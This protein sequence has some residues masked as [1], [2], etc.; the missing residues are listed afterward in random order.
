[1]S[2]TFA[3]PS[4]LLAYAGELLPTEAWLADAAPDLDRALADFMARCRDFGF[5]PTVGGDDLVRHADRGRTLAEWVGAVGS[6]FAAADTFPLAGSPGV[7]GIDDLELRTYLEAV[8][9]FLLVEEAE[10][11]AAG[12][13]AAESLRAAVDA[14]D[15]E[16]VEAL[17]RSLGAFEDDDVFT[18][19]FVLGAG[20]LEGLL[21]RA[22][23]LRPRSNVAVRFLGGAW[24]SIVGTGELVWGLTGRVVHDPSG[25]AGTWG[26]LGSSLWWGVNNPKDF[27]LAII[28]WE[29]LREDPARWLGGLAPDVALTFATAGG[30]AASRGASA[31][32]AAMRGLRGAENLGEALTAARQLARAVSVDLDASVRTLGGR[33]VTWS[34]AGMADAA[35]N[36]SR[37]SIGTSAGPLSRLPRSVVAHDPTSTFR[38]SQYLVRTT[39]QPVTLYRVFTEGGFERGQYWTTVPP[40]GQT[41]AILDSALVPAWGNRATAVT[42]IR[43]PR[44]QVLYEGFAAPQPTVLPGGSR[45]VGELAGGGPQ[46]FVPNVPEHWI[47]RVQPLAPGGN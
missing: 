19:A 26:D 13:A 35:G 34:P 17:L 14:G 20:D 37:V 36:V 29:G 31:S 11:H 25:W 1:M 21:D 24:D 4:R 27:A 42:E 3:D 40:A 39:D 32:R 22:D 8:G 7:R 12:L 16:G 9:A 6:A 45:G 28:D 44:G 5:C 38:G 2:R 47:V 23:A 15:L 18:R 33:Q 46:V 10:S 30:A 43:V 41:Q